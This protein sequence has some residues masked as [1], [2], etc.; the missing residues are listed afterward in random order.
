M[1]IPKKKVKILKIEIIIKFFNPEYLNICIS[2]LLKSLIKKNCDAMRN[3][4]GN[5]S[6]TIEGVFIKAK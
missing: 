3:I 4:N 1:I 6:K 5:I 2:L